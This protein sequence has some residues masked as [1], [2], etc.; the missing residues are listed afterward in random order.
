MQVSDL[1]IARSET[2]F[3]S[4]DSERKHTKATMDSQCSPNA[5]TKVIKQWSIWNTRRHTT[6]ERFAV[7]MIYVNNS[8]NS[9]RARTDGALRNCSWNCVAM[10]CG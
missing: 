4:C 7:K 3:E 8:F 2:H 9:I 10:I 5:R 1:T 6:S